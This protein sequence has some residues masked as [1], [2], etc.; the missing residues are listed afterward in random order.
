MKRKQFTI[1][2]LSTIIAAFTGGA[3]MVAFGLGTPVSA[4][5]LAILPHPE[6]TL[7][8]GCYIGIVTEGKVHILYPKPSFIVPVR[9]TEIQ[10]Q[11]AR[12]VESGEINLLPYEGNAVMFSGVHGGTWIYETKLLDHGSPLLTALV[13][14]VFN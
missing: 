2:I 8:D 10:M 4:Q 13:K 6:F 7:P 1:L 14:K 11:E 3:L 9:L 12:S 5:N